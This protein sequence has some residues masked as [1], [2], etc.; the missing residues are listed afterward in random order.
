MSWQD[1]VDQINKRRELARA[2]GGEESIV[3]FLK[4]TRSPSSRSDGRRNVYPWM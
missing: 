1:E 3:S 2:Q 4:A